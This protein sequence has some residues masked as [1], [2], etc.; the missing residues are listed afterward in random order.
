MKVML[1]ELGASRTAKS[2][3]AFSLFFSFCIVLIVEIS[4]YREERLSMHKI[5]TVYANQIRSSIYQGLSITYPL[6]ALVRSENGKT[7]TFYELA[8]ELLQYYP[9]VSAIQLAPDGI[10]SHI[11]P[12]RGNEIAIGHNLLSDMHRNKEAFLAKKTGKLTLAGPFELVQGGLSVVGRLPIFLKSNENE[13]TFWGFSTVLMRIP[14]MFKQVTLN[15]LEEVNVAYQ[16]SRI[17]PDTDKKQIILASKTPIISDSIDVEI[18]VP[19]AIWVFSVS[20]VSSW[21]NPYIILFQMISGIVFSLFVTIFVMY[22]QKRG[23]SQKLEFMAYHDTL[24]HLPN[25]ILLT[26]R[27]EMACA[28][29]K[30]TNNLLAVCFIDL[31]YFKEVNDT[32]SHEAGDRVLIEV[33]QRILQ[34]IR[35]DDTLSRHGGDEFILLINEMKEENVMH[36]IIGRI[37]ET[38]SRPYDINSEVEVYLS[39][40]IGVT[41]VNDTYDLETLIQEA[42]SAMYEAKSQGRN[43]YVV[44][45]YT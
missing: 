12:L 43:R 33:T 29:K 17:H 24:T 21:Y 26:D 34:C 14:D 37:L 9:N 5:A 27:F 42:D 8:H 18:K 22:F 32:Y 45:S 36:D 41:L 19:N 30:Y 13:E 23:S 38:L 6:A 1:R 44:Y 35:Q 4:K 31:D 39:A 3:F 11:V 7:N 40:S 16:L 10:V 25:R 28:H 20:P 15:H 2:I